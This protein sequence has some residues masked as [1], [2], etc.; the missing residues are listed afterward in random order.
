MKAAQIV[1]PKAPLEIR[2]LE[3]PNP[4]EFEVVVKVK[5]VGVCHSDLHLW[6]GGYDAGSG[7]FMKATDRGVK[8]PVTPGHEVV[9]TVSN[10]GSLVQGIKT[11]D[12]VLVY[13]W[14]GCGVCPAC[15]IGSENLC[16]AP[17]SLGVFQNGGYAEYVLVPNFKYLIKVSGIDLEGAA[18]LACSGLTAFT[19][20]KKANA[21][22]EQFLVIVG[23]GG[24]GLM[25]IQIAKAITKSTIICV[26]LDDNKLAAAK[27]MGADHTINSKDPDTAQKI[28]SICNNKGAECVID[29]VNTPPTVKMGLAV[30]RKRGNL[31]LVGLFG[32]SAEIVLPTIPLK[33]ITIQG[34]YTGNYSD[35]V[36]LVNLAKSGVIN[37]IISKRYL[38]GD[39][40]TALEELKQ[41]KIIGRAVINP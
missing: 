30:L 34:A 3:I 13:P 33:A 6:E 11:G 31:I 21:K 38:L 19:A 37:P 9:G 22:P 4:K 17:R 24:L 23:A 27:K 14:I 25:G 32:G 5:A 26:D 40:N 39:A 35:L 2:D 36:E 15:K 8:F 41:G 1:T 7:S 20:I 28:I 29:F 16:D 10:T 18:S 12:E